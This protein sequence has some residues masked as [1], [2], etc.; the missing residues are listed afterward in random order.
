M[1][2]IQANPVF[3]TNSIRSVQILPVAALA[4]LARGLRFAATAIG[5]LLERRS[6]I[7]D[8]KSRRRT[9]QHFHRTQTK[10][11]FR[12]IRFDSRKDEVFGHAD[13]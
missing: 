5:D 6:A 10:L 4:D 11:N 2:S 1:N 13:A 9:L 8:A 12:G 3:Q 7:A